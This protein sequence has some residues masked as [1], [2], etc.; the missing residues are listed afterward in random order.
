M[1]VATSAGHKSVVEVLLANRANPNAKYF[2][3]DTA[4]AYAADKGFKS[5]AEMLIDKGA[6]VNL[7]NAD[8]ETPL[9][10]ACAA[11]NTSTAELLIVHKADVNAQTLHAE[12]PL[13]DAVMNQQ[14]E[15]A[16][17]LVEHGAEVN[18]Q[19]ADGSDM[20]GRTP[21]H[22]AVA[23][24]QN[25]MIQFL[26]EH[27][28]N[29]NLTAT[30]LD[31]PTGVGGTKYEGFPALLL[32][33]VRHE[34]ETA[35]LLLKFKADVN[36]AD[37]KGYTPLMQ[38]VY[39]Q[40]PEFIELLLAHGAKTELRNTQDQTPLF[41]AV[42]FGQTKLAGLLLK[43]GA[44]V[45][46]VC[47]FGGGTALFQ[48]T[49]RGEVETIRLLLD[50]HAAVN[51]LDDYGNTPLSIAEQKHASLVEGTKDRAAFEQAVDLLKGAGA[52]NDLK[53]RSYIAVIRNSSGHPQQANVFFKGTNSF[54]RH[55]LFELIAQ[56]YGHGGI[57]SSSYSPGLGGG[58]YPP[59]QTQFPFP[60]LARIRIDR[61]QAGGG[62]K[63]IAVDLAAALKSGDCSK[64]Q[65]LEWGDVVEIPELDHNISETWHGLSDELRETLSTCL[66]R[67]V[68]IVVKGETFPVKLEP[69]FSTYPPGGSFAGRRLKPPNLLTPGNT[70]TSPATG[71]ESPETRHLTTFW[72]GET[73]SGANVLR[74]SSDI[75]RVKVK[76]HDPIT[77]KTQELSF[78][79]ESNKTNPDLWLRD[80]D[81]IEIPE[82]P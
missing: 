3:G 18:V 69:G 25:Q 81:V 19:I 59:A 30:C 74:A 48:A 14:M 52:N 72:L 24:G 6:N 47:R 34:P 62:R 67:K 2:S 38:A 75:S 22:F 46:A 61:L 4:L 26:L 50:H 33:V 21:L 40:Y 11:G 77:H 43:G 71:A 15:A 1:I 60:D 5:I 36:Q 73:V 12:T 17:L 29:P 20:T 28:A 57:Q 58:F 49:E 82:K 66:G 65:W 39:R 70:T 7:A 9:H 45:N 16:R 78:N 63:E 80:G 44:D 51:L 54:N 53:R 8:G 42:F 79:L 35:E 76:H 37:D 27:G 31:A 32:A 64:D 56:Y 13:H 10:R 68:E 23:N 55:S 41:A